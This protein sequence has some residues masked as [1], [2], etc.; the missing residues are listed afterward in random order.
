MKAKEFLKELK[1]TYKDWRDLRRIKV[2][3]KIIDNEMK[4][5]RLI[6]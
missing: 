5:K 1:K 4:K 6:E 2:L 3:I